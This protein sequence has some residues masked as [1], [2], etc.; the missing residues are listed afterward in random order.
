MPT[1]DDVRQF[2]DANPLLSGELD[3]AL[4]SK[5]WFERF[6]VIKTYNMQERLDLWIGP[7]LIEGKRMLDVGCG[8]GYWCRAVRGRNTTY[9]GIDI[10]PNSVDLARTSAELFNAACDLRVG[11]AENLDFQDGT[12][13]HVLSEGVIH[14]T[15]DTAQAAKEIVRVL[16]VGGTA[17]ISLYYKNIL[18]RNKVLFRICKWMMQLFNLAIKGRGR[19]MMRYIKTPDDFIRFYDGA[20][21]PIGKGFTFEE[22]VELVP[23]NCTI[24][25]TYL[26]YSPLRAFFRTR[27]N[28]INRFFDKHLGLMIAIHF[29]KNA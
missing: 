9:T 4:G 12:F 6:D 16:K 24:V 19:D 2:W 14:H 11:N 20:S 18:L 27:F 25:T 7:D 5:E 29:R 13:D 1:I 22:A 21:N 23:D 15:P 3:N 17:T 10:S 26:Y 28:A 8:P